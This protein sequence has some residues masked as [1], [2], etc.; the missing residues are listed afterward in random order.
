[1]KHKEIYKKPSIT[2][3]KVKINFFDSQTRIFDSLDEILAPNVFAQSGCYVCFLPGTKV[4]M[5]DGTTKNIEDIIQGDKLLSFDVND[6]KAVN[7]T[8]AN[9]LVHDSNKGYFILNNT[10]KVT[11]NHTLWSPTERTWKPVEEYKIGEYILNSANESTKITSK[12]YVKG[13]F[14]VYNLHTLLEPH[15][16]FADGIL[17]HNGSGSQQC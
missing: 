4:S 3:K 10:L 16:Y 1:M 9:T 8:V 5:A 12:K 6:N 2:S 15:N 11:G 14:T 13:T 7:N 17:A